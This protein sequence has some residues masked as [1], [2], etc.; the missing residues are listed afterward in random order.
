MPP[1]GPRRVLGVREHAAGHQ[2]R[3]VRHVDHQERAH[4]VGDLAEPGEVDGPRIGRAARDDHLGFLRQGDLGRLVVVDDLVL[5]PDGVGHGAEPLARLV[6]VLAVGQVAAGRQVHAHEGVARA[7]GGHEDRLVRLAAGMRL[8]VGE[9]RPEQ[10]LGA[11]DGQGLGDVHHL[12]AAV[13]ALARVALG[14]LVGQHAALRLQHRPGDDVLGRDQF[15]L[16][17]LSGLF[18]GQHLGQFRVGVRDAAAEEG[19]GGGLHVHGH[20][21]GLSGRGEVRRVLDAL[22]G[23]V[24]RSGTNS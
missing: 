9:G 5:G 8:D 12:A 7:H 15:D 3:E 21:G 18:A 10:R 1:R 20:E 4:A 23:E 2:A 6:D 17:L 13:V 24:Q 11:F 14:V 19:V 22:P 16:I